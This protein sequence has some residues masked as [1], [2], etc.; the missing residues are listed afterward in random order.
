MTYFLPHPLM[1]MFIVGFLI[2]SPVW[3]Q[4]QVESAAQEMSQDELNAVPAALEG[5]DVITYYTP[6]GPQKGSASYLFSYF[7]KFCAL[8]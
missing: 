2:S 4:T 3:A 8:L 1:V 7:Q 6:S 5:Y